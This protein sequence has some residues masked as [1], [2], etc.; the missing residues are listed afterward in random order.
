MAK[1]TKQKKSFSTN[2]FA[3][4]LFCTLFTSF[5]QYFLKRGIQNSSFSLSLSAIGIHP[6]LVIGCILY[7]LGAVT[8]ILILKHADLSLAYP[9]ISLSFI[10]VALL[11]M[12]FLGETIKGVQW[13]GIF[14]IILGVY[15]VGKGGS[16]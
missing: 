4:M 14:I 15:F 11:S 1:D 5:G 6:M 2:L 13:A 12:L 9:F 3:S 16:K 10:W 7:G 8:L